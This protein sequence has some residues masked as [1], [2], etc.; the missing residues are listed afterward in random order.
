MTKQAKVVM[1][2]TATC[3]YCMAARMLFKKKGVEFDDI[4]VSNNPELRAE[5]EQRSGGRT[6]PQIFIDEEPVGGF[7]DIYE[8]DEKGELDELLGLV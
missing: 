5:M 1:Y 7:D 8:L 3:P 4:S 2:G 6:V